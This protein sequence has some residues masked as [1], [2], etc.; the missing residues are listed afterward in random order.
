MRL[1]QAS[2]A[3]RRQEPKSSAQLTAISVGCLPGV[4]ASLFTRATVV[5]VGSDA[6]LSSG[7]D[8]RARRLLRSGWPPQAT[9][10]SRRV[11]PPA[12]IA[13]DRDDRGT[14]AMVVPNS[15]TFSGRC[16]GRIQGLKVRAERETAGR[17][18]RR[19]CVLAGQRRSKQ[20]PAADRR[21]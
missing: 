3:P 11:R 15:V 8:G 21:P 10:S 19:G 18:G 17:F 20:T 1:D 13:L 14:T 7:W 12:S 6:A 2:F 5:Q 9:P 16:P 4:L